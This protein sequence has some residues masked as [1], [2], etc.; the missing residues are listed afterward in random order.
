M[1]AGPLEDSVA[2][3]EPIHLGFANAPPWAHPGENGSPLGFVNVITVAVLEKMDH[4]NVEPV[5]TDW[6]GLIPSLGNS[7]GNAD[8]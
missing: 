1:H 5:V 3:G 8:L 4:T 2:A 6:S 7:H